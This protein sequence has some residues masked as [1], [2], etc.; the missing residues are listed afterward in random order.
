[1]DLRL[2][3]MICDMQKKATLQILITF[4]HWGTVAAVNFD[5]QTKTN[6]TNDHGFNGASNQVP[7]L[8]GMNYGFEHEIFP[9]CIYKWGV[10]M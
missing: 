8:Y 3:Q 6:H 2:N 5:G 1:M 7:Y 9:I 10:Y 4:T